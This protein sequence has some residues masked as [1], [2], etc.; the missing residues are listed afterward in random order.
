MRSHPL[1]FVHSRFCTPHVFYV[2]Y[3]K[4]AG[5]TFLHSE[6]DTKHPDFHPNSCWI[7][8]HLPK[9]TILCSKKRKD[10]GRSRVC[11]RC[12]GVNVH[13]KG[14]LPC[15]QYTHWTKKAITTA[16][17]QP[18]LH[19]LRLWGRF[20]EEQ[21]CHNA[22]LTR[23]SGGAKHASGLATRA[24]KEQRNKKR[25]FY[26]S[27]TNEA[28]KRNTCTDTTF[29]F[30]SKQYKTKQATITDLLHQVDLFNV[31]QRPNT[32]L[33]SCLIPRMHQVLDLL[34]GNDET[35]LNTG[36][37]MPSKFQQN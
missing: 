21:V 37:P 2:Q 36:T 32:C 29:M 30:I 27:D 20:Y 9:R 34:W 4:S 19:L 22:G 12:G 10:I 35:D 6:F 5:F 18:R 16:Y 23:H 13:K 24:R 26:N 8:Q 17:T 3:S 15:H 7:V 11:A 25:A 14:A 1:G 28:K 31:I 33:F